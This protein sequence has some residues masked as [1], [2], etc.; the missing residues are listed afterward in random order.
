M[1]RTQQQEKIEDIEQLR[2]LRERRTIEQAQRTSLS[3]VATAFVDLNLVPLETIEVSDPVEASQVITTVL[4]VQQNQLGLALDL[5]DTFID[6]IIEYV[7]SSV[8]NSPLAVFGMN[9]WRGFVGEVVEIVFQYLY[10]RDI[11]FDETRV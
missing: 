2:W 8:Q 5:P 7:R 4:F 9:D 6:R 1:N 10:E 3:R 11:E